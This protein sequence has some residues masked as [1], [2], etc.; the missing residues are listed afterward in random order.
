MDKN[1]FSYRKEKP[2]EK[3]EIEAFERDNQIDLPKSYHSFLS[4]YGYI[5]LDRLYEFKSTSGRNLE[6]WAMRFFTLEEVKEAYLNSKEYEDYANSLENAILLPIIETIGS[7]I[8]CLVCSPDPALHGKIYVWDWDFR[9]T[10]QADSL[11]EFLGQLE[12]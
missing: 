11:E 2:I 7:Q 5:G 3:V 4:Q 1:N 8:I 6:S 10:Y 9:A 12:V